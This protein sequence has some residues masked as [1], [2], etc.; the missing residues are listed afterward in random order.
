MSDREEAQDKVRIQ[1]RNQVLSDLQSTEDVIVSNALEQVQEVGDVVL[2]PALIQIV[3][4]FENENIQQKAFKLLASNKHEDTPK[5]TLQA[6]KKKPNNAVL[7]LQSIWEAGHP[8]ESYI[9]DLCEIAKDADYTMAIEIMSIFDTFETV[10]DED[11]KKAA[12]LLQQA[13]DH[14]NKETRPLLQS[15]IEILTEKLIA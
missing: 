10:N 4:D 13:A 7:L 12:L 15:M 1:K 2:I 14:G 8:M 3:T 11:V 5:Y 6:L 9:H